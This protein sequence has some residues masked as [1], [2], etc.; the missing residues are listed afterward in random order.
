MK[1]IVF[2]LTYEKPGS[3]IYKA[4]KTYLQLRTQ[5]VLWSSQNPDKLQ[6]GAMSE[7]FTTWK[8]S[9]FGVILVRI[10]PYSDQNNSEYGNFLR[11]GWYENIK[12]S[13]FDHDAKNCYKLWAKILLNEESFFVKWLLKQRFLKRHLK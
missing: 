4:W 5:N 8:V 7:T 12:C 11:S 13:T 6:M 1:M 3:L 2:W 10:F 9:V